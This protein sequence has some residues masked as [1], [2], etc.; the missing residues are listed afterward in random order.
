MKKKFVVSSLIVAL[1]LGVVGVSP[2]GSFAYDNGLENNGS[3]YCD[4]ILNDNLE[5]YFLD[6]LYPESFGF[7][8]FDN[9]IPYDFEEWKYL[10]EPE[11]FGELGYG[12]FEYTND[13][14]EFDDEYID[15]WEDPYNFG[16][17]PDDNVG[18]WGDQGK[19]LA[20]YDVKD[21]EITLNYFDADALENSENNSTYQKIWREIVQIVPAKYMSMIY[22]FEINTDGYDGVAAYVH[23]DDGMNWNIAVDPKDVLDG[24]GEFTDEGKQTIVHELAHIISLNTEQM[25]D[26]QK[27]KSLYVVPEGTLKKDAYLNKFYHLFWENI[28]SEK[29]KSDSEEETLRFYEKHKDEFVTE[30]AATNPG[31]D[32]AESFA[33]FVTEE[34]PVGNSVKEQ[35]IKFFYEYP[36]LVEMREEIRK[37]NS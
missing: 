4:G 37:G 13:F 25:T 32:F 11:C 20:L 17:Y 6:E 14:G 27:D 12:E 36:E 28:I 35:K 5:K 18:K 2:I 31:E 15:N 1:L 7:K 23:S 8:E 16:D 33:Y 24:N 26:N 29:G 9:C 19:Q 3:Y 22:K 21:G 30:Y 10:I 34:K